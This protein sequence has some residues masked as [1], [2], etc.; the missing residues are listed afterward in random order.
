[1]VVG[2]G[3]DAYMRGSGYG[4]GE[5]GE[6]YVGIDTRSYFFEVELLVMYER[7]VEEGEEKENE[8]DIDNEVI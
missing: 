5:L 3:L 1:M 6:Y 8:D 4:V 2:I 7:F